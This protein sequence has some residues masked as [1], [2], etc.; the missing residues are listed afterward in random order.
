MIGRI[1]ILTGRSDPDRTGLSV[2]QHGFLRAVAPKGTEIEPQGF[3]WQANA[4]AER[5]VPLPLA[6]ARNLRVW[7]AARWSQSFQAEAR[8]ALSRLRDR[9]V[10]ILVTGSSGL[11]I[12]ATG[13][14]GGPLRVIALGP[15]RARPS[16][17]DI[18]CITVIGRRDH[19][20]RGL[21]R[22]PP[23]HWVP[24][25]HMDYWT[26]PDT[27]HLVADLLGSEQR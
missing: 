12:L 9:D 1:A 5:H 25:G 8:A 2:E 15:V 13:W 7:V 16:L 6:A 17:P 11:D 18:N 14:P 24:G 21:H 4:P 10:R 19:L 26:C 22:A 3:P 20:S 27:Q 23:D